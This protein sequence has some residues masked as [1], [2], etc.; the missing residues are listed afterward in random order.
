[1]PPVLETA[2]TTR[3]WTRVR[4]F[5]LDGNNTHHAELKSGSVEAAL[6]SR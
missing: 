1:M 2:G 5:N 4:G 3:Y 6:L